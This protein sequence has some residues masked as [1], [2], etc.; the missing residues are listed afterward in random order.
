MEQGTSKQAGRNEMAMTDPIPDS[1][2]LPRLAPRAANSHKG[3]FGRVL[4]IGGCR[5]MAGAA[6][7][8][9]RAAL[10]GGAGL[11]TIA[12]ADSCLETVAGFEPAYMTVPL[13]ADAAGRISLAAQATVQDLLPNF[14][15]VAI[16]PGLGRSEGLTRLVCQVYQSFD[17][18]LVIDADGLNALSAAARLDRHAGPR[19]LTPHPGEFRRLLAAETGPLPNMPD[20]LPGGTRENAQENAQE[21]PRDEGRRELGA[22]FAATHDVTLV[23]KGHRTLITDGRSVA[24][25][26]TGNPG[27]ATGGSGDVLTGVILALLGQGLAPFAAAQLGAHV[28]GLAG[29]LAARTQG[30]AGLI[31]SDLPRYLGVA[32]RSSTAT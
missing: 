15:A 9:G 6:A 26:S 5:G 19:V 11:V 8:A 12:T 18:T 24:I 13:E 22:S 29:D 2:A 20:G 23:L 1:P 27:M 31:A 21:S 17:K 30:Q 16:G 7:L 28:H 10:R 25:N 4:I 32:L 3:A 14:D